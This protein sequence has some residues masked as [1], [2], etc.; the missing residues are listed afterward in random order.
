M[1]PTEPR[2]VLASAS[3]RRKELLERFAIPFEIVPAKGEEAPAGGLA[4]EALVEAL[5]AAK[6]DEVQRRLQD[7]SAVIVGADTVVVLDGRVLGK[8]R[9]PERAA[10]MLRD[11]S[12]KTHQVWTGV[13]VRQGER[14][15]LGAACTMVRFR[16]LDDEEIRA[17][18]RSGEPLD[19]AGAY[20]Y[21]GLACLF[22]DEIRGDFYNVMGLPMNLLGQMLRSFGVRLL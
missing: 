4:P 9:T 16:E 3:P 22:V 18:V 8:P 7:G 11:L 12:G 15:E 13:C 20:G 17:Y 2:L 21:Q 6:A 19:K 5:A 1:G 14:S 10:E